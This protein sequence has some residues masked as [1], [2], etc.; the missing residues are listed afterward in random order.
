MAKRKACERSANPSGCMRNRTRTKPAG[1]DT[2][3]AERFGWY[4]YTPAPGDYGYWSW[5]TSR[6]E[7]VSA[8]QEQWRLDVE[9]A[10]VDADEAARLCHALDELLQ[11]QGY[12]DKRFC[13]E[14]TRIS[15]EPRYIEWMG[16]FSDLCAGED[17]FS[18]DQRRSFRE[19]GEDGGEESE[20]SGKVAARPIVSAPERDEFFRFVEG[21]GV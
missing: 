5:F 15:G 3:G 11:K 12:S 6:E 4:M 2:K 7:F 1:Q 13:A 10:D 17:S 9:G 19:G 8:L 21:E 16:T 14:V 18:E 20:R